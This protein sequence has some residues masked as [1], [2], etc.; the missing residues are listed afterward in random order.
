MKKPRPSRAWYALSGI[1]AFVVFMLGAAAWQMLLQADPTDCSLKGPVCLFIPDTSDWYIHLLSYVLMAPLMLALF[2][3]LKTWRKQ[4]DHLNTLTTNMASLTTRDARLDNI[5]QRLN[6]QDHVFLLDS[7]DC[8]SFCTG[9]LSP[10]IYV[11]RAIVESLTAE[12]LEALLLHERYHLTN[13]DPLRILLGELI[14]SGLFFV[15]VLRDLFKRYLVKKEIA[16][17]QYA[18]Q[19]QGNR[20]GIASTLNKLL[21]KEACDG[22]ASFAVS[23]TDALRDRIDNMLGRGT[24]E[25]IPWSHI[26]VSI[27]IPV[28]I[29]GILVR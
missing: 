12:E 17:D 29:G 8:I 25:P 19:Y 11:S 1:G 22:T 20:H 21:Q 7:D 2:L 9:F 5:A 6:L 13:R 26:A 23:G 28:I 4:Q 15:P 3:F 14:V 24:P 10:R 18:I 27:G 16:A